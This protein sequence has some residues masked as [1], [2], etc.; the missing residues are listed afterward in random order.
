MSLTTQ[1]IKSLR[2]AQRKSEFPAEA[3]Y[4]GT[5]IKA[6]EQSLKEERLCGERGKP[7]RTPWKRIPSPYF[8]EL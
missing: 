2:K 7:L 1:R 3:R 5:Q 8:E 6:L 4:L